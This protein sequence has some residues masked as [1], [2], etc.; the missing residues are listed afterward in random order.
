MNVPPIGF[1]TDSGEATGLNAGMAKAMGKELGIKINFK[2]YAFAGLQPALKSGQ[3]DLIWDSMNDTAEREKVLDFIDYLKA[4]DTLLLPA[5][6]PKHVK[7]LADTC[8]LTLATVKGAAQADR[9]AAA[10]KQCVAD[11]HKEIGMKLYDSAGNARLQ[12]KTGRIDAFIGN[13][14]VLLYLAKTADNGKTFAAVA[15]PPTAGGSY[16]GIAF[17]KSDQ[18]LRDAFE[19]AFAA[20]ITSG[21]YGKVLDEYGLTDL[22]LT[23]PIINGVGK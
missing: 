18:D 15:L 17:E 22:A 8:G 14:P 1:Y 16:Y 9:V 2:Q 4:G 6:N 3:I 5:G 13:A 11:G 12:V 20:I 7:T 10:S 21:E 23:E 19:A